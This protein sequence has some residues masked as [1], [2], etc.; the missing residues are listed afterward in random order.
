MGDALGGYPFPPKRIDPRIYLVYSFRPHDA[1]NKGAVIITSSGNV[2]LAALG[3]FE[4][5]LYPGIHFPSSVHVF[6]KNTKN[7]RY[8]SA[9]KTWASSYCHHYTLRLYS[10]RCAKS[11]IVNCPLN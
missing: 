6:V 1:T 7:L 3:S 10:L 11:N 9:I 2:L 5:G 4:C 8:L